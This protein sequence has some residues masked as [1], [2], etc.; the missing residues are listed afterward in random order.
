MYSFLDTLYKSE[1]TNSNNDRRRKSSSPRRINTAVLPSRRTPLDSRA[2][3]RDLGEVLDTLERFFFSSSISSPA[4]LFSLSFSFRSLS[5]S[6]DKGVQT[7]ATLPAVN[8]VNPKRPSTSIVSPKPVEIDEKS[9]RRYLSQTWRVINPRED[10]EPN[11]RPDH[12]S[13]SFFNYTKKSY[14]EYFFIHPDWY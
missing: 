2:S 11:I 12:N 13:S 10:I 7:S 1:D 9:S 6:E 5:T 14:P 4:N 3:K 8:G